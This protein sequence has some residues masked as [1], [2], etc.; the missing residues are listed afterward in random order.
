MV[1]DSNT[2][3]CGSHSMNASA[4]N[5]FFVKDEFELIQSATDYSLERGSDGWISGHFYQC[6]LTSGF[7]P[8]FSL[9]Q[10]KTTGHAVLHFGLGRFFRWLQKMSNWLIWIGY[11]AQ[12]TRLTIILIILP[13]WA[14]YLS[15]FTRACWK[16]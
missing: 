8:V 1:V 6:Q 3:L 14:A 16:A 9:T 13:N 7:Q 4:N 5:T 11:A 12:F 15:T 2:N 10:G